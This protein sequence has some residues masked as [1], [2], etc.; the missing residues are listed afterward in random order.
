MRRFRPPPARPQAAAVTAAH[1]LSRRSLLRAGA[2]VAAGV[3]LSACGTAS[4]RQTAA[5]CISDD[6]SATERR[7]VFSN[8]PQYIDVDDTSKRPTLQ[9]F[10]RLNGIEVTYLEEINANDEFFSKIQNQL[11]TCHPT[12]RDVVVLSDWLVGLLIRLGWVQKLD[13]TRLPNV[14]AHLM[15]SLRG[16]AVDPTGGYAVPWQGGLVGLAYNGGVAREIRTVDELLTRPDL[17]GKVTLLSEMRDT[18]GL[19]LQAEGHDP[20]N[21]TEVQFDR[22][23]DK[24]KRAVESGQIRRFTGNDYA[25][26]LQRGDIAACA[27]WSG[28]VIQLSGANPKIQFVA[29]DSG[30]MLFSDDLVVPNKSSQLRNAEKLINYYYDPAVAARVAAAVGYICPVDGAQRE[31][32]KIDPELATNPLIF[33]T[34]ELLAKADSFKPMPEEENRAY[35]RKFQAVIA[36]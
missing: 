4:S 35:E 29:P 26:D 23:L 10:T 14:A 17:K 22:A 2:A 15:P 21:F 8:W 34:P 18:M 33:P 13:Q 11:A 27:G 30:I 24:L 32:E 7:L 36:G 25:P 5:G 20:A 12:G 3:G 19:L 31:M 6:R 1:R 16:R 9:E 28:D